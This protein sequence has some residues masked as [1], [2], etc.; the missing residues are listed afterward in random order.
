MGD[1]LMASEVY[2][3]FADLRAADVELVVGTGGK[4]RYA[5]QSALTPALR[6]RV[7]AHR[8]DII[9]ALSAPCDSILAL[10]DEARELAGFDTALDLAEHFEERAGI[11]EFDGHVA[12][13]RAECGALLDTCHCAAKRSQRV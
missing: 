12:R 7:Q 10:V 5:P 13:D 3:L 11:R 9:A 2:A 8:D 1:N 4:L 6:A